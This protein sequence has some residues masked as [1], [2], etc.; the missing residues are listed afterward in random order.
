VTGRVED[1]EEHKFLTRVLSIIGAHDPIVPLFFNYCFHLVHEPLEVPAPYYEAAVLVGDDFENYRRTYAAMVHFLDDAV[2]NVTSLLKQKQMYDDTLVLFLSDNG[3][4]AFNGEGGSA[5]NNWPLRGGKLQNWQGGIRVAAF[6][7]G[8]WLQQHAP[9]RAGSRLDGLV[10][11][12]DIYATLAAL[13]GVDPTDQRAAAANLPPIDSLDLVPYL[14]GTVDASPRSAIHLDLNA[15]VA[16]LAD[17]RLWKLIIGVE[18]KGCWSG[19][20]S[21]NASSAAPGSYP[22]CIG[23][24]SIVARAASLTCCWTPR[25]VIMLRPRTRRRYK[26]CGHCS[27]NS[28]SISSTRR[29]LAAMPTSQSAQPSAGA[30][31]WA[32]GCRDALVRW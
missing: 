15:A 4:A 12:A 10:S 9:A 20:L 31:T 2:G 11:I 13:A 30:A 19:P 29:V 5:G 14:M 25:S 18:P 28:T 8:G 6:A 7:S 21:P 27:Q 3:G 17:G 16:R 32:P 24:E 23:G 1:F 22:D 26:A